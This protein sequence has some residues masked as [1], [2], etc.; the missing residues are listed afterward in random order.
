VFAAAR[1]QGIPFRWLAPGDTLAIAGAS[2]EALARMGQ[3]LAAG[4]ALLTPASA[5][6]VNG[7]ERTAWWVV[8]RQT[9]VVRDE[10]E[11]GRHTVAAEETG[12]TTRAVTWMDRFRRLGC[13][14]AGV[15]VVVGTLT[16]VNGS[17]EGFDLVKNVAK[18][19]EQAADNRRRTEQAR[20]AA[21]SAG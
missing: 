14:V 4:D 2:S 20:K 10:H 5:P 15:A 6:L 7:V 16:M 13:R 12:A 17:K 11:S 19:A 3:R 8:D 9:G 18:A 1:S 21:C